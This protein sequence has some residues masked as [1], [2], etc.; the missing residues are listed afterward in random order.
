MFKFTSFTSFKFTSTIKEELTND[1]NNILIR[2]N[3]DI[4]KWGEFIDNIQ[5]KYDN[6]KIKLLIITSQ[7]GICNSCD[8]PLISN[9]LNVPTICCPDIIV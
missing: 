2:D 4:I 1:Y 3:E 6:D 9:D 8:K 5:K 7:E